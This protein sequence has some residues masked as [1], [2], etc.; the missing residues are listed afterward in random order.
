MRTRSFRHRNALVTIE[1]DGVKLCSPI[2]LRAKAGTVIARISHRNS[3]RL[4]VCSSVRLSHGWI[5]QKR[6]K[7]GPRLLL[8]TNM[9]S[10]TGSRLPPNSMTLDDFERQNRSFYRFFW[11]FRA[12]T[13]VYIIHM[14][15]P[16]NY[17]YAIQIENLVFVY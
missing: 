6:C 5:S 2:L 16:R 1:C 8:V 12:A 17:R 4:S 14:V 15:A 11:R 7:I 9:K 3:V 13:Q 10:Y